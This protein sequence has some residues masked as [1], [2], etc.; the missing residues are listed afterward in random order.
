MTEKRT[1]K[2]KLFDFDGNPKNCATLNKVLTTISIALF[3]A[4]CRWSS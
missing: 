4:L 1:S 2:G 3:T